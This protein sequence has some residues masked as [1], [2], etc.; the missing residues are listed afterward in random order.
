[1]RLCYAFLKG[2]EPLRNEI[3]TAC[4]DD[5]VLWFAQDFIHE[6]VANIRNASDNEELVLGL[7]TVAM[8]GPASDPRDIVLWTGDLYH[9]AREAEM[10][11]IENYFQHVGG[12]ADQE[13]RGSSI[14]A[15][16]VAEQI[17]TCP[18]RERR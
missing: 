13:V 1:M 12:L 5:D 7:A 2:S 16:S 8:I 11:G 10:P 17:A 9:K 4:N 18:I 14:G 15:K 3:S 6:Q